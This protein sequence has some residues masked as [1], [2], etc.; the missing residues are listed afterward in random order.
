MG[1]SD[2]VTRIANNHIN[3][4]SYKIKPKEDKIGIFVSIS[5]TKIPFKGTSKEYIGEDCTP[6]ADGVKAALM[7]CANELKSKIVKAN[8][9]KEKNDRKRN[10]TKYVGDVSRSVFNMMTIISQ[11]SAKRPKLN[12]AEAELIDQV[13]AKKVTVGHFAEELNKH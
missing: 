2:V 10:L 8:A 1:G 13:A 5:S 3:W 7:K 4:S 11:D 9:A 6:I 12:I